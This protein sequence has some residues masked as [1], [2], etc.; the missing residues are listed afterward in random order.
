MVSIALERP[1]DM[2]GCAKLG[3]EPTAPFAGGGVGVTPGPKLKLVLVG[4]AE[5][6][7]GAV[8]LLRPVR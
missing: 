7:G 2:S 3:C 1:G 4:G 6:G 8:L 5:A